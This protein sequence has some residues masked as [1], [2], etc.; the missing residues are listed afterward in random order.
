M[1]TIA[2][3]GGGELRLEETLVL[4]QE[5]VKL[6]GKEKPIAL[7]IPTASYDAQ[8][9]CET[10]DLIYGEKLGCVTK[11]LLLTMQEYTVTKLEHLILSADLIYVGGGN[12]RFLLETWR[13]LGVDKILKKAYHQGVVLSGIS[14]GSICWYEHGC[15]EEASAREPNEYNYVRLEGLGLL[16]GNHAPHYNEG[17]YA[18]SLQHMVSEHQEVGIGIDNNCMIVYKEDHFKVFTSEEGARVH[19]IIACKQGG[20]DEVKITS[21]PATD[22][23][24]QLEHL[25]G[26]K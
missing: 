15:S 13:E 5:I 21:L 9:Y 8:G 25:Y 1:G 11:H 7:F 10:F 26:D 2:V 22:E 14:A 17:D 24:K 3:I 16:K 20:R 4:D 19:R 18:V 6:T 23:E 12:T